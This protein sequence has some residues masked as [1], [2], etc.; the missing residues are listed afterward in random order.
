MKEKVEQ[1]IVTPD[2]GSKKGTPH[3]RKAFLDDYVIVVDS[4]DALNA[5]GGRRL[6]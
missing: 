5:A 2:V 1:T 4:F 3:A 6:K